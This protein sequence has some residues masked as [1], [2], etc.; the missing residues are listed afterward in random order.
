LLL[1]AA[2]TL[3]RYEYFGSPLPQPVWAKAAGLSWDVIYSGMRY[4]VKFSFFQGAIAIVTLLVVAGVFW[5]AKRLV[6]SREPDFFSGV[7]IV[8][9]GTYLS[10]VVLSG[11]DWM[12]GGRFLV[13]ILPIA[14]IYGAMLLVE[15]GS[16]KKRLLYVSFFVCIQLLT[17]VR[18]A[19]SQMSGMPLWRAID[20]YSY[21]DVG[22]NFDRYS[23]FER[24]NHVHIRDI[25]TIYHLSRFADLAANRR[26]DSLV[27]MS[28]Q[29][30][31]V[32][33]YLARNTNAS[34]RFLDMR[35][36]SDR[37]FTDCSVTGGLK[38]GR[39][40]LELGFGFYFAKENLMDEEC[41]LKK[42]DMI[43]ALDPRSDRE[44]VTK[45]GYTVVYMQSGETR[46]DS[47][48]QPVDPNVGSQFIAVRDDL[49][50]LLDA[51]APV[52]LQL[53]D[54]FTSRPNPSSR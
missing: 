13:H 23:W 7:S 31:M 20:I 51:E 39:Y 54:L 1:L 27:I 34:V 30:G 52:E 29:M 25:P 18:F 36:L 35:G 17:L 47:C 9:L 50:P 10:F 14:F 37:T 53:A 48:W 33:H 3:F 32:A 41:H 42:P 8:L 43:Y 12:D 11:G 16:K 46:T 2:L 21:D 4:V 40:G 49:L 15:A 44:T 24:T 38:K 22:Y 45:N 19:S 26:Q 28:Y 5:A 6:Q